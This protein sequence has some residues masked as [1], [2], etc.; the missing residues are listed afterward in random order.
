MGI[1]AAK[2]HLPDL[3]L[4]DAQMPGL[5]GYGV[6]QRIKKRCR[7]GAYSLPDPARQLIAI[8]KQNAYCSENLL[9]LLSRHK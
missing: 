3:I 1:A 6:N 9:I 7:N 5:D 8:E 4:C 2:T